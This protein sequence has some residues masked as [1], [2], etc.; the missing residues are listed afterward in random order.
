MNVEDAGQSYVVTAELMLLRENIDVE[1]N[2]GRF[3]Q[4]PLLQ[5]SPRSEK[6]KNHLHKESSE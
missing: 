2:E 6:A 3:S 5:G 4:S 1:L